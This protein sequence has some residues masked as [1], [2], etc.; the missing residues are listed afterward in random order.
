MMYQKNIDKGSNY[1]TDLIEAYL[2]SCLQLEEKYADE[3]I[4]FL[5]NKLQLE[6]LQYYNR[7]GCW[8]VYS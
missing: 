7:N 8:S 2:N 1:N 3:A 4:N 5:D 6:K